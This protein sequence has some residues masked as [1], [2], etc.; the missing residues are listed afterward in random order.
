MLKILSQN[1]IIYGATNGIKSLVPFLM[2]PILTIHLS[3]EDFGI[4]SLVEVCI[5]FLVPL[6]SLNIASSINVEYFKLEKKE[7]T[8]ISINLVCIMCGD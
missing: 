2:L 5:L 8:I 1:I 7:N 3:V 6:V 4:L